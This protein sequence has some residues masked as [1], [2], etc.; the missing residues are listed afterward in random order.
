MVTIISDP[1]S[2]TK[3]E[4]TSPP[5]RS[6]SPFLDDCNVMVPTAETGAIPKGVKKSGLL[7]ANTKIDAEVSETHSSSGYSSDTSSGK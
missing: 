4:D 3:P 6:I 1:S 2:S 7:N 5:E